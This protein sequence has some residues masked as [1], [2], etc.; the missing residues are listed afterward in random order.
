MVISVL[1]PSCISD[2]VELDLII[3][4]TSNEDFEKLVKIECDDFKDINGPSSN[5]FLDQ[6]AIIS[7]IDTDTAHDVFFYESIEDRN[8]EW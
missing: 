5:F 7:T 1:N 6:D 4:E 8:N 3:A 2:L